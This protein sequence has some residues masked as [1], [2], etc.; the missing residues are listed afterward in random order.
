[1]IGGVNEWLNEW[2]N[3]W[4]IEWLNEWMN[5]CLITITFSRFI[6]NYLRDG[7]LHGLDLTPPSIKKQL[8]GEAHFYQIQSLINELSPA[9]NVFRL[10]T[11]LTGEDEKTVLSWLP[12]VPRDGEWSLLYK[13]SR[14]G[15]DPRDFHGRCDYK[16]PTIT[17]VKSDCSVFGGY[18]EKPWE[19]GISVTKSMTWWYF[20]LMC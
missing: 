12:Y 3:E 14:D 18:T 10:T 11:I 20:N 15:W 8:L 17:F 19:T 5:E 13:A 1:M 4:M 7:K 6:L 2:M 16:S 9:L